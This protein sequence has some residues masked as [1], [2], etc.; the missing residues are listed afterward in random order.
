[1]SDTLKPCP[2]CGPEYVQHVA[3]A[4]GFRRAVC[5]RCGCA[6]PFR[7]WQSRPVEDALREIISGV[8]TALDNGSCCGP[9]TSIDFMKNIPEEVRLVVSTLRSDLRVNAHL[10]AKATDA[11]TSLSG[12]NERLLR[13]R[14][15]A[16]E[17]AK[18]M[19]LKDLLGKL[20][21]ARAH[22]AEL[23]GERKTF[24]R[25]L[26][27]TRAVIWLKRGELKYMLDRYRCPYCD[28]TGKV[29]DLDYSVVCGECNGCGIINHEKIETDYEERIE[30]YDEEIYALR[31]R[32]AE[33]EGEVATANG[34]LADVTEMFYGQGYQLAGWHLNGDLEP[35]DSFFESNEWEPTRVAELEAQS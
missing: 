12:E 30:K 21:E 2:F 4:P 3:Y 11:N 7:T 35:I 6:M 10:L 32:V 23:E 33:L 9:G 22:V 1:M 5:R 15:E 14:D 16:M 24:R 26:A 27:Y 28:G 34:K 25:K 20:A 19:R 13:E 31:A 17:A 29:E 18:G 8:C